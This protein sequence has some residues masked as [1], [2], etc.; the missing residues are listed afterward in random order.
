MGADAGRVPRGADMTRGI[1]M[2]QLVFAF[3]S[4]IFYHGYFQKEKPY[5]SVDI[6]LDYNDLVREPAAQAAPP[7]P[8]RV[9]RLR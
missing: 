6:L 5:V 8:R 4:M 9:S 7:A 1:S 2:G 3:F